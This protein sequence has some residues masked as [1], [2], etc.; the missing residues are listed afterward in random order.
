M[1]AMIPVPFVKHVIVIQN[2]TIF[3]FKYRVLYQIFQ[4]FNFHHS[5]LLIK[6]KHSSA[7]Y[8]FFWFWN[9]AAWLRCLHK[10]LYFVPWEKTG[11]GTSFLLLPNYCCLIAQT[12]VDRWLDGFE[13]RGSNYDV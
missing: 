7:G 3:M 10:A 12:F 2:K 1:V 4:T 6:Q 13:D 5:L 11:S 8:T 9:E